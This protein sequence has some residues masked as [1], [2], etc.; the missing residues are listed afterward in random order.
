MFQCIDTICSI[1]VNNKKVSKLGTAELKYLPGYIRKD[2]KL[3]FYSSNA[4]IN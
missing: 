3:I 4:T 2:S 1:C